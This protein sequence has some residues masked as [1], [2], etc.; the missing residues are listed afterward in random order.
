MSFLH[1][2]VFGKSLG[3]SEGKSTAFLL[4]SNCK[5]CSFVELLTFNLA[6][7][8]NHQLA[9]FVSEEYKGTGF[10]FFLLFIEILTTAVLL[11]FM[12]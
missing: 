7:L 3:L 11:S 8:N 2:A 6:F 1:A 4:L 10:R 5:V 9:D 12:Y